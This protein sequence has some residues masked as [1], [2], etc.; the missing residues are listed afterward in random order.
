M[1]LQGIQLTWLGHS[2]FRIQTPEGK[3]LY[4]DPWIA[5]NPACP[6]SEKNVKKAD[7]LICTHGHGDHIGDAVDVGKKLNPIAHVTRITDVIAMP[8]SA[9]Q[10]VGD[11]VD[12]GKKLNPIAVGI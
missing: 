4:V 8:V 3:T 2:T 1:N 12:V 9:D 7:V 5:G 10:H 6:A 11:A